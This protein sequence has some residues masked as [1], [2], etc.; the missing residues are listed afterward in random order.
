MTCQL[1][2][3]CEL[4]NDKARIHA[5]GKLPPNLFETYERILDRIMARSEDVQRIVER[6][7]RWTL[8]AV[9]RLTMPL[10]IEA[11]TIEEDENC[12]DEYAKVEEEEVFRCCTSLIRKSADANSIE[13]AHFTV[14]EFLKAIDPKKTPR[15]ARFANLKETADVV[16]GRTC[17]TYLNYEDFAKARIQDLFWCSKNPFWTYAATQWHEHAAKAWEDDSTRSLLRRFFHYSISS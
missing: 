14:K 5:L 17:L 13:L 6:T 9:K 2:Y 1:D 16:L 15:L 12:L 3:L 7:L 10:L 4:P 8:S 11:I